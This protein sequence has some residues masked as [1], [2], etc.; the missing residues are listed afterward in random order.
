MNSCNFVGRIT[1]DP[2]LRQNNETK[3][4]FFTLAIDDGK[5]SYTGQKRTQFLNFLAYNQQANFLSSY[6]HKGDCIEVT[7]RLKVEYKT[8][9]NG[10]K[11]EKHNII[12][13]GVSIVSEANSNANA[14]AQAQA[15]AQETKAATPDTAQEAATSEDGGAL[16]FE[17]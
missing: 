9:E 13:G 11:S 12:V 10:L 16:P 14:T 7:G 1:K 5:D 6:A 4:M 2:E 8:G 15:Q 3:Y 17:I